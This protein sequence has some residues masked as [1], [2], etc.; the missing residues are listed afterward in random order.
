MKI[1]LLIKNVYGTPRAYPSCERSKALAS[2]LKQ[3]TF[4]KGQV[5]Q[6]SAI[7]FEIEFIYPDFK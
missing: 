5:D 4:T 6:I 7:G 3:K 2:L 1:I